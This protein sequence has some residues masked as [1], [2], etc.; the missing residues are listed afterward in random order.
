[1]TQSGISKPN[2]FIFGFWALHQWCYGEYCYMLAANALPTLLPCWLFWET[3]C[4]KSKK[5]FLPTDTQSQTINSSPL[6][7]SI[8]LLCS[9]LSC[10]ELVVNL[11]IFF[12][13]LDEYICL[14][15]KHHWFQSPFCIKPVASVI[16]Y[17]DNNSNFLLTWRHHRR[18]LTKGARK[19][20][21]VHRDMKGLWDQRPL[22]IVLHS[23]RDKRG[24]YS[25]M[26]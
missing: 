6:Q 19:D 12:Y 24:F 13:I 25:I 5:P 21:N 1:M 17:P 11:C 18:T 26:P 20:P 7:Y 10:N 8:P 22:Q 9:V 15:D 2:G 14:S 4:Q 3:S 16:W 23:S